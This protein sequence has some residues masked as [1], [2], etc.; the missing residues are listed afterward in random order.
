MGETFSSCLCVNNEAKA[1]V[2][3]VSL[4]IEIQTAT[5]KLLLKDVDANQILPPGKLLET[6]VTHEIKELGQHVLCCSLSYR[7]GPVS[8]VQTFR[9]YYKFMVSNRLTERST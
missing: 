6:M 1:D 9:K 2:Q 8:E 3:F 7:F 4:R 5:N